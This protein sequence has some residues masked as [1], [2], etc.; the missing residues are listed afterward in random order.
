MPTPHDGPPNAVATAGKRWRLRRLADAQG[1]FSMVAIDQRPPIFATLARAHGIAPEAVPFDEVVAAKRALAAA[2]AGQ[3]SAMLVDPNWGYPAAADLLN[4]AA[5]LVMTL[6]DHRTTVDRRSSAI[7]D[8]SVEKIRALGGDAVKLLAW[9]H[10]RASAAVREHQQAFVQQVGEDCARCD[11]PFVLELL[12]YPL[13]G[14]DADAYREDTAKRA[15]EVLQSVEAFAHARYQ[16]D[17]FKLES[18]MPAEQVPDPDGP[19]GDTCQHTYRAL[20]ASCGGRPWVMLSAGASAEAFERVVR[21][22]ARAGA[23]GFLAG[24]ALWSDGLALWPDRAAVAQHLGTV[25]LA[26]LRHLRALMA[27]EGRPWHPPAWL[28]AVQGEGAFARGR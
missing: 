10:P 13:A 24:R 20:N 25:G 26:R 21:H 22:A 9:Y 12:L 28:P 27:R 15:D 1:F 14:D 23:A 8:W 16:V 4:P 5:G 6:E 3:A 11:T 17:L 19:G 7:A 2:F 18:P